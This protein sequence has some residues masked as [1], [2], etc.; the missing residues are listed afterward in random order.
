MAEWCFIQTAV[1]AR[2]LAPFVG[3]DPFPASQLLGT[4]HPRY[5]FS[6]LQGQ[7]F[8]SKGLLLS[9]NSAACGLVLAHLEGDGPR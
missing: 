1:P 5:C 9:E 6:L 7:N 3:K 8:S 4:D 2:L